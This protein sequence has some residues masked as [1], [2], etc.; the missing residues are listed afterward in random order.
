MLGTLFCMVDVPNGVVL[1]L[2]ERVPL[3][4]VEVEAV[5]PFL[6]ALR[7]RSPSVVLRRNVLASET[8]VA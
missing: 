1:T 4:L 7:D 6:T 5:W 2:A 3:D 8:D